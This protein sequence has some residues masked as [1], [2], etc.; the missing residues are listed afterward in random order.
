GM[1][2]G[3]GAGRT[4]TER[5]P[6]APTAP[7]WG[8]IELRPRGGEP[9]TIATLH[10]WVQNQGTAWHFF[11]EELRR[12]FQRVLATSR[13]LKPPPRPPGSMVD[14]AEGEVPPAARE[15]LG[16]SLAAARLLGKRT[17]ELHA[18]LLSPD[19]AA[20]SPEPYSALDQRSVYQTKRNLTGKVLRQLRSARLQ[21]RPAELAQQLLARERDLYA[22]FEPPLRGR[23][24]A[25]RGRT[26]G[27]H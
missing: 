19:D 9:I 7:V 20:F 5:S 23:L 24:T 3:L 11:R 12:Y 16:S 25:Q 13:E 8:A 18:A 17:A 10:G 22:S 14:L 21:G 27:A 6:N 1:N 26:H 2:P 4:L 15:M